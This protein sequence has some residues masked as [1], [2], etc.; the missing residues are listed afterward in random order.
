MADKKNFKVLSPTGI[1]GYGFPGESFAR[2]MEMRPDVIA[3]DAG[4]TDPGP[5]YLGSGKLLTGREN[6]KRDLEIVLPAGRRAGVPVIIGSAGGA[7]SGEHLERTLEIIREIALENSLRFR[8][9]AV[10]ADVPKKAVLEALSAGRISPLSSV[11]E[12]SREDV[13]KSVSIVAQMGQEPVLEALEAGCEVIVCGRCYDPVPF[14]AGPVK[15]GFDRGLSYHMGKILECAAIAAVPGSGCDCVIGTITEEYFE[16]KALDEKRVFTPASTA[17]HT[18]YEKSDP[19]LL[20]GP[21]GVLDLRKTRFEPA[22]GGTVRVS[23]SLFSESERYFLKLEGAAPEGFRT[24]SIAGV[25]DPFLIGQIDGALSEIKETTA[26]R[27]PG[28][29]YELLFRVYGKDAVMGRREPGGKT[30]PREVGLVIEALA[31]TKKLSE[32]VCAFARSTLL[33]FGYPGRVSTAGNLAFPYSPSDIYCGRVYRFSL[34]HLMEV[35]DPAEFFPLE[36]F[37]L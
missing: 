36:V 13:A 26:R 10:K 32:S 20:P 33:H 8:L 12:L 18:L 19:E 34:Y 21:G 31:E 9:G 6:L 37:E 22:G 14:A 1:L 3:V 2:G 7:G 17:A 27:F 30:L 5:Y 16:L 25:R 15:A 23:G 4:S 11:P 29:G 28:A 24:I 35:D